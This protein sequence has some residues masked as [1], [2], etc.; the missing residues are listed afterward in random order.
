MSKIGRKPIPISAGVTVELKGSELLVRGPKGELSV[1]I[2]KELTVTIN[3]TQITVAPNVK[4]KE[5]AS[6]HGMARNI[7]R[8]AVTGV[9]D[10]FT[11]TLEMKGTGYRA[12]VKEGAVVLIVGFSRPVAMTIPQGI[13]AAV[14]RNVVIIL[15]GSDRQ[16]L[17]HFAAQIRAIRPPEPY[18]GKGIKYAEEIIKRKPGK[19]A[20]AAQA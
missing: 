20:K 18:K 10:G 14:E 5:S 6:L 1:A 12:E 3:D 17:G 13:T 8:N 19:A 16:R 15:T 11:R 7:I 9:S 4:T 2:P